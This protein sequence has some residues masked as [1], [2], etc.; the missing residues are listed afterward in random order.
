MRGVAA[1]QPVA[2]PGRSR[3]AAHPADPLVPVRLARHPRHELLERPASGLEPAVAARAQLRPRPADARLT[4]DQGETGASIGRPGGAS[5]SPAHPGAAGTPPASRAPTTAWTRPRGC[6]GSSPDPSVRLR[7]FPAAA[8]AGVRPT[9]AARGTGCPPIDEGGSA[10]SARRR[11][12][13]APPVTPRPARAVRRRGAAGTSG[14]STYRLNTR[15]R[16]S[17]VQRTDGL[18]TEAATHHRETTRDPPASECARR[19]GHGCRGSVVIWRLRRAVRPSPRGGRRACRGC[20]WSRRSSADT[21]GDRTVPGR[22]RTPRPAGW[23]PTPRRHPSATSLRCGPSG[24]ITTVAVSPTADRAVAAPGRAERECIPVTAWCDD[25]PHV[26]DDAS[27]LEPVE[28][29][30]RRRNS[31]PRHNRLRG[32]TRPDDHGGAR[33]FMERGSP[34]G[35]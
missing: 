30:D 23:R 18:A 26:D 22:R 1:T 15:R 25:A 5:S 28:C 17:T 13:A 29:I 10:M 27:L 32:A 34:A 8:T 12:P 35:G 19:L 3:A 9:G 21:P 2:G 20:A 31:L 11:I 7:G 33:R 4:V 24:R 6:A 16:N 14:R